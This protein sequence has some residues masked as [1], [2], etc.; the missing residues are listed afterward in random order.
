MRS[1]SSSTPPAGYT[2]SASPPHPTGPWLTQQDLLIDLDHAGRQFLFLIRDR[3][4]KFTAAFDTVF[5]TVNVR[6]IK[7]PVRAPRANAIAERFVGSIRRELLDRILIINQRH[8]VA[9]LGEYEHQYNSHRP[10]RSLGQAAP[11]RPLPQP[12][13]NAANTLRRHDRLGGLLHEYQQVA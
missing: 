1:S 5:T 7:T 9:V 13:T 8:A 12:T 3:D 10:H 11:L 2:S 4:A 6:I